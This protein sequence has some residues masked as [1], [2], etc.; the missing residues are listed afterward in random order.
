MESEWQ[1]TGAARL[2]QIMLVVS[3]SFLAGVFAF[4]ALQSMQAVAM[5]RPDVG[6]PPYA[7]AATV[8]LLAAA[9]ADAFRGGAGVR[10]VGLVVR[11][12]DGRLAP[13]WLCGLRALLPWTPAMLL[14]FLVDAARPRLLPVG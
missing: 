5:R 8:A 11:R 13:R 10:I 4:A 12:R 2:V 14:L 1:V 6:L 3:G 9:L 7:V